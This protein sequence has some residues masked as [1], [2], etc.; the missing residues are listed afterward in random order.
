MD[1]SLLA[2]LV[3]PN[4]KSE[5]DYHQPQQEL[6]CADCLIAYPVHDNIPVMLPD[7]ARKLKIDK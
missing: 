2:I 1:K 4:C 3:C 6:I 5:L 7:E